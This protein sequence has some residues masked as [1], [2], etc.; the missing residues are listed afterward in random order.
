VAAKA[1]LAWSDYPKSVSA[2][3]GGRRLRERYA[4]SISHG[5]EKG[6]L[7][8]AR[9]PP[10]ASRRRFKLVLDVYG[11][12]ER[13]LPDMVLTQWKVLF[14]D[15]D[16]AIRKVM[17]IDLTDAG[18]Q[19][20]LAADG[21]SGIDLL[22]RE[23]CQIVITDI[24]M[25]GI[26]GIEVVRRI[27]TD[28]PDVEVI[29]VTGHGDMHLAIKALQLDAS[30]FIN[31]P[32]D[33]EALEVALKR[34]KERYKT[35]RDLRDYTAL[36]EEKWMET[37]EKLA[38]TYNFQKNLIE[39]SIDGIMACDQQGIIITFNK[40][41]E[42][43]L[44][45]S[46]QDVLGSMFLDQFFPQGQATRIREALYSEK[47][48]AKGR[49]SVYETCLV[50]RN[51]TEIPVQLSATVLFDG[52]TEIGLVAFFRDLR[53]IRRLEQQFADQAR[54]LH[55]DKMIS[56]GKLAGSVVHEIN[57]P[58]T[59]ILNY[60]G[61]MIKILGK[62]ELTSEHIQRFQ[63]YLALIESETSRCS[64]IVTNLLHFSR[65]AKPELSEVDVN[66]LVV[67][68]IELSQH[69]LTLQNIAVKAHLDP[70]LPRITADASQIQQCIINIIFNA[71]DAMPN[72]GGLTIAS[73]R[74]SDKGG[75]ELRLKDTGC[76]IAKEDMP[77]LFEPFFTTK[78]E[79]KG[80]GL[81]LSTVYG[82]IDR[83]K[84]AISIESEVGK[85][86]TCTI[87]LPLRAPGLQ[88]ARV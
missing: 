7:M 50:A 23:R 83:H 66:E 73:L 67:K 27:K 51:G 26:D 74:Q 45:Y 43:I 33:Q 70:D 21:E 36:L 29:V 12:K 32:I 31:K 42:N 75:I 49:L 37:S 14:I 13:V 69:K 76:G 78:K 61:L 16:E 62:G 53:D 87:R 56:L 38:E 47:Y 17:S 9:P 82:I 60:I 34:A 86:T 80:V 39:S 20:F 58:L 8:S 10:R 35:R 57:N 64:K 40:S 55:Q 68:C 54:L 48:E 15:D 77:R 6:R 72:G 63:R 88:G 52:G 41:L 25:P 44:G 46:K 18:Y 2:P 19:V 1:P 4:P 5:S 22:K 65:K 59:G 30:D 28:D 24:R 84:G 11:L 71:M 3:C 79:G 85:G 81:G